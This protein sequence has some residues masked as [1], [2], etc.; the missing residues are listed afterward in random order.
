MNAAI[1]CCVIVISSLRAVLGSECKQAT[2]ARC[3]Y[4]TGQS[5]FHIVTEDSLEHLFIRKTCVCVFVCKEV[6][7]GEDV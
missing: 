1:R 5:S 4:Q 6:Q 7:S 3:T 2:K